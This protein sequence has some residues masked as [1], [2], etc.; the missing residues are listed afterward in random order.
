MLTQG[1]KIEEIIRALRLSREEFANK[2]NSSVA[3]VGKVVRNEGNFGI[4]VYC[5]LINNLNISVDWLLTGK[6]EMFLQEKNVKLS[7]EF[8][9]V[10]KAEVIT[11]LHEYGVI[12]KIK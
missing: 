7:D 3:Q 4:D 8:K 12:D 6:G 1:E 11:L 9:D 2:I 5:N 10:V